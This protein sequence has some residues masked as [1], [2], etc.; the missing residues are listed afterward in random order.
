MCVI[1]EKVL[2]LMMVFIDVVGVEDKFGVS[3]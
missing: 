2:C 3:F 1:E